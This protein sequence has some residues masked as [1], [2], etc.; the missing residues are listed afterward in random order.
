MAHLQFFGKFTVF[1]ILM[2]FVGCQTG[3]QS[4]ELLVHNINSLD[5]INNTTVPNRFIAIKNG[6]IQ[7]IGGEEILDKYKADHHFELQTMVDYGLT[8]QQ[9]LKASVWNGP[10]YF[11]LIQDYGSIETGKVADLLILNG[12]PLTDIRETQNIRSVIRQ[13]KLM[14]RNVLDELLKNIETWVKTK[15]AVAP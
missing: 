1:G 11:G 5:I 8:P 2:I 6:R 7:A 13:G 15:E 3:R 14:D 12:N 4:V 10:D 9:A